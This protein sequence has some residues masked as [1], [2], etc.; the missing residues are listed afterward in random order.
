MNE[1]LSDPENARLYIEVAIEDFVKDQDRGGLLMCIRQ[2]TDATI[3]RGELAQVIGISE[4]ELSAILEDEAELS[5]ETML[6]ILQVLGVIGKSAEK[7][8]A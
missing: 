1:R 3:G 7:K 8:A 6:A 5:L 4:E 2:V